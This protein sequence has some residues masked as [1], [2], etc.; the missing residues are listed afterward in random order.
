MV[1][2][3]MKCEATR[4]SKESIRDVGKMAESLGDIRKYITLIHAFG[5]CDTTSATFSQGKLSILKLIERS[6][7]ARELADVFL[8]QSGTPEVIAA[9]GQK[10]FV[11]LYGGKDSDSL[12]Y[13]RYI[14][15]MKMASV[16][17]SIKP[18]KLPHQKEPHIFIPS[19][20]H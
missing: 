6:K 3:T 5:G 11:I 8:T 19:T 12:S 10:L 13:L 15:Y 1:T 9:A 16:S 17:S 7:V 20:N 2:I 4:K 18:E 14:K